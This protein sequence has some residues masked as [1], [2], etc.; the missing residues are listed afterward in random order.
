MLQ[1]AAAYS[2]AVLESSKLGDFF[3]AEVNSL[4]SCGYSLQTAL[5]RPP[6]LR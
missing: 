5:L 3:R 1:I 4:R 2:L 6:N